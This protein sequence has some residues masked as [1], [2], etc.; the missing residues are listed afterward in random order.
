MPDQKMLHI[1]L[2]P[3]T[4]R[5]EAK[6]EPCRLVISGAYYSGVYEDADRHVHTNAHSVE[7][8]L[9]RHGLRRAA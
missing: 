3:K 6:C 9:W 2:S 7:W 4:G 1:H 5:W 8:L